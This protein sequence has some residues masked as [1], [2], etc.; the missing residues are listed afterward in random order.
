MK[1]LSFNAFMTHNYDVGLP[2]KPSHF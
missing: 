1:I 2:H